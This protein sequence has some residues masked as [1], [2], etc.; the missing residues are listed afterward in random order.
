[1]AVSSANKHNQAPATTIEQ[2]C[3]QFSDQVGL[4]IDDGPSSGSVPSTVVD[5][6]DGDVKIVRIGQILPDQVLKATGGR[7]A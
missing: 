1:L 5:V 4:Y 3:Q 7:D 2:A 6:T